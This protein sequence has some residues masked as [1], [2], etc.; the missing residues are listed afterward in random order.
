MGGK[1]MSEGERSNID[2]SVNVGAVS[3]TNVAV[4]QTA[5]AKYRQALSPEPQEIRELLALLRRELEAHEHEVPDPDGIRGSA[6][7]V[8][9]E[10]QS[11]HPNLHAVRTLL[12]GMVSGVGQVASLAD[13]VVRLQHAIGAML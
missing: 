2:R 3:G 11:E 13:V 6:D 1:G 4:G 9:K 7:L 12:S 8:E 5:T 10:L